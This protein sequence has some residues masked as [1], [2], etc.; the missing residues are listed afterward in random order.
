MPHNKTAASAHSIWTPVQFSAASAGATRRR[1]PRLA[2]NGV[3][4]VPKAP[5][6]CC[7]VATSAMGFAPADGME[8]LVVTAAVSRLAAMHAGRSAEETPVR[9]W[10]SVPLQE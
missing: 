10:R 5:G 4:T 9:A 8:W 3:N 2:V 1:P 7:H 6:G